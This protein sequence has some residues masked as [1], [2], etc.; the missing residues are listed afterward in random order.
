MTT[1]DERLAEARK[2]L[3]RVIADVDG[4]PGFRFYTVGLKR[5]RDIVFGP[6]QE[7]N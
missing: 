3:D 2:E 5:A 4:V 1:G 6:Q 7:T